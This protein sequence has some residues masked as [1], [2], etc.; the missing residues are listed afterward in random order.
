MVCCCLWKW[1]G[2]QAKE[3]TQPLESGKD[4]AVIVHHSLLKES[5]LLKSWFSCQWDIRISELLLQAC[6]NLLQ[7]QQE[8]NTDILLQFKE[9]QFTF[10]KEPLLSAHFQCIVMTKMALAMFLPDFAFLRVFT[11]EMLPSLGWEDPLEKGKVT[12][13]SILECSQGCSL[14]LL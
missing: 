13:S 2:Q 3:C 10:H 5:V 7:Q 6:G 8:I 12:H 9:R 1:K 11:L 14:H 4:K